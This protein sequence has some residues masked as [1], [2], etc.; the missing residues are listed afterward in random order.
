MKPSRESI[1]YQALLLGVVT[2]AA[3]GALAIAD[4]Q[5]RA[6]ITAAETRDLESTLSQVLPEGFSDNHLLA[7]TV[8]VSDGSGTP[9]KVYRARK[10]GEV[11][12]VIYQVTGKGYAGPVVIVM[13]VDREGT[14]LGVRVTRHAETPGLGD[15]IDAAKSDWVLR[16]NG[17][18]LEYPPLARWSVKKDCGDFDQFTGA[19]ITPRAV[20]DAVKQGL[21]FFASHRA[22]LVDE[23]RPTIGSLPP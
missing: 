23:R 21:V 17:K 9:I 11:K 10:G 8:I 18:S 1:G 2:L 19:T 3:G 6:A 14:I 12:G 7:D 20:V 15:K 16:F 22:E 13:G 4:H 5:T